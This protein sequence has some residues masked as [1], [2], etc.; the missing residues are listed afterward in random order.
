MI[1]A[2]LLPGTPNASAL[3]TRQAAHDQQNACRARTYASRKQA[4]VE[5]RPMHRCATDMHDH[6][7]DRGQG[8][9][10]DG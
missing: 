7:K 10:D 3:S 9:T 4:L 2:L 5:C 8:T 6:K 1:A